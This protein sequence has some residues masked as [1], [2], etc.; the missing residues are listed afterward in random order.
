MN[1]I[2]A[3]TTGAR[4]GSERLLD[5]AG[6]S[7]DRMPMLHVIFDRMV[8]QC[9]EGLRHLSASPAIFSVG[10]IKSERFGDILDARASNVVVGIFQAPAW[11]S[12]ILI[13]VDHQLVFAF[14]EALFGGD[15][16]EPA[17]TEQRPLS[18]VELNAAQLI[19]EQAAKALQ[20]SFATIAETTFKF[21]QMETRVDFIGVA[22]R[23][24]FAILSTINL[25]VLDRV[26]EMIVVIPQ[27]ALNSIRHSLGRVVSSEASVRDPRWSKQIR[28]EVGRTEVTVRGLIEESQF[29]LEDIAALE[30]GQVLKLQATTRSR[31]KLECNSQSLFWCQLGQGD[32]LYTLRVEESVDQEQ[33]FF[34]DILHR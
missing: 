18:N 16:S 2:A 26:G 15:G 13:G 19:C 5:A 8:A 33:E 31:I 20:S 34:D 12:S 10:A 23:S 30:V 17:L 32:G 22:P 9:S 7:I 1:A 6:I 4:D 11:D 25:R 28:G 29:C 27:S 21:E 3:Q 14:V 24:N